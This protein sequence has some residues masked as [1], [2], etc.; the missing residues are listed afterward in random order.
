MSTS[1]VAPGQGRSSDV[2]PSRR[3]ADRAYHRAWLS[4]LLFPLSLVM[5]AAVFVWLWGLLDYQT[6]WAMDYPV[7]ESSP[8]GWGA[9]GIWLLPTVLYAWPE[10]VVVHHARKASRLG[11]PDWLAP[12]IVGGVVAG[13]IPLLNIALLLG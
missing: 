13:L 2:A 7:G 4:Q 8:S 10:A 1:S 6:I 9:R 12:V 5:S 3:L 11:R